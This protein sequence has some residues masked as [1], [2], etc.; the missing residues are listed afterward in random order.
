MQ[1]SYLPQE[2]LKK[3]RRASIFYKPRSLSTNYTLNND[4]SKNKETQNMDNLFQ[5]LSKYLL[6]N[7]E[8]P[9]KES[10][11]MV[12][13]GKESQTLNNFHEIEDSPKN[14]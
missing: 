5:K 12:K 11:R 13:R 8:L 10:T 4:T 2:N 3:R 7:K 14:F 9:S 6:K 1:L